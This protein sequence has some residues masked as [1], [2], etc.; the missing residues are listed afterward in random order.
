MV[1]R[2]EEQGG[3]DRSAER[4]RGRHGQRDPELGLEAGLA[5]NPDKPGRDQGSRAERQGHDRTQQDTSADRVVL[6]SVQVAPLHSGEVDGRIPD[7]E[8]ADEDE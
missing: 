1:E 5:A 7:C 8:V 4:D 2:A 3:A 6:K